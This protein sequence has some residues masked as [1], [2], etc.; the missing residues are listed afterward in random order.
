MSELAGPRPAACTLLGCRA[1]ARATGCSLEGNS[2]S[3][4]LV[5]CCSCFW[6]LPAARVHP[7]ALPA[8]DASSAPL[9]DRSFPVLRRT[10]V[11]ST[12]SDAPPAG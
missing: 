6:C 4:A 7:L 9:G 11:L 8:S 3:R 1:S 2:A 5:K 10:C 12:F